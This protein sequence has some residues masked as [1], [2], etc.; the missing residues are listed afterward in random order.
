M[1]FFWRTDYLL[2][3]FDTLD[4]IKISH[5]IHLILSFFFYVPITCF[6][7]YQISFLVFLFE[8][9][10]LFYLFTF[11]SKEE[12]EKKNDF[13]VSIS[14]MRH[15]K[16]PKCLRYKSDILWRRTFF[17]KQFARRFF[18]S[19]ALY[20]SPEREVISPLPKQQKHALA[21][22]YSSRKAQQPTWTSHDFSFFESPCK[23]SFSLFYPSHS[24]PKSKRTFQSEI[25]RENSNER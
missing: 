19:R 18:F 12:N 11:F 1:I 14:R 8:S 23:P 15:K 17:S 25:L 9:Y 21:K 6:A 4:K 7:S 10:F 3:D 20:N 24:L 2:F 5:R 13:Q 22:F 16:L